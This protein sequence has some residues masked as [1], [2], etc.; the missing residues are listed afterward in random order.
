MVGACNGTW[1]MP[2]LRPSISSRRLG[3]A[4]LILLLGR[5]G[6]VA[7]GNGLDVGQA[8]SLGAWRLLHGLHLYGALSWQ[9]PGGLRLY[10]PDTYGPFAYYAYI[11]FVAIFPLAYIPFAVAFPPASALLSTLLPAA[12][13]DLL[14]LAVLPTL[15]R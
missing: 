15:L 3:L 6:S 7:A 9:G 5:I 13:F 11:P 2:E 1:G 14:T 8:S 4:I 12:S 10:R